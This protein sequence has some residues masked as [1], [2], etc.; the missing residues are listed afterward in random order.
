MAKPGLFDG[1]KYQNIARACFAICIDNGGINRERSEQQWRDEFAAFINRE[2][3][4]PEILVAID[5]WLG[6]LAADDL[7]T[8]CAG[9]DTEA[10]T[11]MESAPPCTQEVLDAYF[12]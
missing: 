1:I 12:E 2:A 3:W 7:E 5:A 6:T 10:M 9:V 4:P 8:V 11:L